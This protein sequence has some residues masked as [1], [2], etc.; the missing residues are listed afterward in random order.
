MH[1]LSLA[2]IALVSLAS[3][4]QGKAA[5]CDQ[6][7]SFAAGN[8][9]DFT[10]SEGR[11]YRV[12]LPASYDS[13]KATPLILSYHGANRVIDEQVA[14]DKLSDP[15][16][17]KDHIVVYLQG[18]EASRP[19]H[20]VWEGAP[21]STSD[22]IGFTA[23]V[24]EAVSKEI[25][26]DEKRIY[27]TGKSQGGGFVGR[28]ACDAGLSKRIAAFAPVSGAYYIKEIDVKADCHPESVKVPCDAGRSNIPILAFHGGADATINYN[29]GFR[30]GACLPAISSWAKQ[31]AARDHLD[32][33][34]A[35]TTIT[36][37]QNGVKMSYG[38][39]LVSLVYDGDNIGHAWPSTQP[40]SDNDGKDLAAFNASTSIMEF[41]RSHKLD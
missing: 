38:G 10:T 1:S 4:A 32:Q 30:S 29:G 33:T 14:L 7:P 3:T 28:L 36:G 31:W 26:V 2:S 41:F 15:F 21:D 5:G 19:G 25:C 16:F 34:P 13:S 18:L 24:L 40:N 8:F 9:K 35:N 39:G 12:W 17:N 23:D 37:A 20:T 27:A 6:K 11:E 22:D